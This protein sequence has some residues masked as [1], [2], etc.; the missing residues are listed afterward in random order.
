MPTVLKVLSWLESGPTDTLNIYDI[1]TNVKMSIPIKYRIPQF[2][3]GIVFNGRLFIIGGI[4]G[5]KPIKST[6]EVNIPNIH[7]G[8]QIQRKDMPKAKYCHAL[9]NDSRYIYCIGGHDGDM[10]TTNC[11]LYIVYKDNWEQTQN[12]N[13]KRAASAAFI[14]R[15]R[16]IYT[17]GGY[18][19]EAFLN[20]IERMDI[21]IRDKWNIVNMKTMLGT[22]S[23]LQGMQINNNEIIIAVGH[24]EKC[25][26]EDCIGSYRLDLVNSKCI[27]DADLSIGTSF[28]TISPI[29]S[30]EGVYFVN[31]NCQIHKY[32]ILQR[33]WEIVK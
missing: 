1:I 18:N 6:Y 31:E 24:N 8:L 20:S 19:G 33:K 17:V 5:G 25:E 15:N 3:S 22:R 2:S 4:I 13:Q 29:K 11:S 26:E 12:L 9:C 10:H 23:R 27:R 16:W 21:L 32:S 28:L 14:F 7:A 30:K